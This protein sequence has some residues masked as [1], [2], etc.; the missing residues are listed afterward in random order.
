MSNY[1]KTMADALREMYPINEDTVELDEAKY[2]LY[3]KD[4]S[5]AMQHAYHVAKKHHGITIDPEEIDNKVATGPRKPSEGKTNTYRLKGDKGAVQ[6]QVY[7]KGGSKPFELNMYKEEVEL[8]ESVI[9]KVKEI[10]S[11]KSAAKIDGVMV[12]SFTASAISQIYDKVNDANKKKMDSL[13]ITKLANLAMKMMQKNEFVPEEVDLDEGKQKPYVSSD[14]DGKHVMGASGKIVK[15]FKDM[16]SANAYL[17]KNYNELMKEADLDEADDFKPHMMYDPKTGKGYKA[18][19]MDDHLRM[20]KMG[21]T[22]DAPKKEEVDLDE[23]RFIMTPKQA[24]ALLDTHADEL[25]DRPRLS[26]LTFSPKELQ[27]L[28]KKHKDLKDLFGKTAMKKGASYDTQKVAALAKTGREKGK[29]KTIGPDGKIEE[30]VGFDKLPD[31]S[32]ALRQVRMNEEVDLDEKAPKIKKTDFMRDKGKKAGPQTYQ[33]DI[34]GVGR[35]TVKAGNE[36]MAIQKAMTQMKVNKNIKPLPKATVKVVEETDLDEVFNGTKQDVR[37][38][39]RATE[40]ALRKRSS[41]IQKMLKSKTNEKGKGLTDFEF[42]HISDEGDAIAAELVYRKKGGKDPISDDI[43]SHLKKFVSEDLDEDSLDDFQKFARL[44]GG[45]DEIYV[46]TQGKDSNSL[47]VIG[48]E[49]DPNKAKKIRDRA[50]GA[51]ARIYGQM[52]S[53]QKGFK[54]KIGDPVSFEDSKNKLSFIEEVDLDEAPRRPKAPKIKFDDIMNR[55]KKPKTYR[56]DIDGSRATVTAASEKM[57]IQKAMTKLKINKKIKPLPKATVKVVEET[58][59]DEGKMS[60]LHQYIKDKKSAEE[61]AKLMKVDVKTI[62]ALMSSYESTDGDDMS[63][64]GAYMEMLAAACGS[65]AASTYVTHYDPMDEGAAAD[66]RRAMSRDKDF[67]RK[68]SADDDTD[69]TDDDVKGASKNIMMQMRKA[70][71]LRGRFDVEFADG[72][73]TKVS[74]GVA[75]AVQSKY[76]S[77]KKPADKEKFQARIGKSYKDMLKALKEELQP[78]KESILERMNRKI[79]EKNNG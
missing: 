75:M 46:V 63:E 21:Y 68:D 9:D 28:V 70:Q 47:K 60:Q 25:R 26:K 36:K 15:S 12:D 62:K 37:K 58:D 42:D 1:R 27:D 31:M 71:S 39:T 4:F 72:K 38:I 48:I 49:K 29:Y 11:K 78:K 79:K 34:K 19:T 10:A 32:D 54:L 14:S 33:V 64:N 20:K 8:D 61:I 5:S 66:A 50:K 23:G 67:S 45:G 41:Q 18:D 44:Y 30:E 16:D 43:P 65:P 57:A 52:K 17:K 55:G 74:A 22:H 13:P 76:N 24:Q 73:K 53:S 7:N 35:A 51:R 3:H 2:E 77:L 40:N 56:V 69:A 59:L 6:I